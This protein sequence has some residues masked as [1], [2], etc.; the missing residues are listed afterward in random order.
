M[1]QGRR[2][3]SVGSGAYTSKLDGIH[4]IDNCA[5][6]SLPV[7]DRSSS[8]AEREGG[9]FGRSIRRNGL[10]NGVRSA[11]IGHT[12]LE[13]DHGLGGYIHGYLALAFDSGDASGWGY[14]R[15]YDFG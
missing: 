6:F 7:S 9:G 3:T 10:A 8:V 4:F 15:Q 12:A 5:R 14:R 1:L 11:R 13:G 2:L